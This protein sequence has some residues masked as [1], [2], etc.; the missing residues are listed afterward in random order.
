[1]FDVFSALDLTD[2]STFAGCYL[3]FVVGFPLRWVDAIFS[4]S[5]LLIDSY[6]LF[7]AP[8][9]EDLARLSFF[10]ASAAPAA[11]CCFLDFAGIIVSFNTLSQH[12]PG[13]GVWS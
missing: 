12:S 7:E 4:S 8:F 11:I 3:L 5:L 10:A 6:M 2:A 9:S 13:M 1:M